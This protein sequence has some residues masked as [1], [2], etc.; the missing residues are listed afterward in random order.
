MHQTCFGATPQV[1]FCLTR[2]QRC[3]MNIIILAF[4]SVRCGLRTFLAFSFALSFSF[5]VCTKTHTWR[6]IMRT[7]TH[8]MGPQAP[9]T[10]MRQVRTSRAPCST[11]CATAI[12]FLVLGAQ[13]VASPV[14]LILTINKFMDSTC[15]VWISRSGRR[16]R[17]SVRR[18]NDCFA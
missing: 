12:A 3:V 6:S 5:A 9:S 16:W 10:L 8:R 2:Y 15:T 13:P 17:H 4:V 1:W 18:P 14:Q 11:N 7:T